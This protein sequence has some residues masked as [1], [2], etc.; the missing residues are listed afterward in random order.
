MMDSG[1]LHGFFGPDLYYREEYERKTRR[2]FAFVEHAF[3]LVNLISDCERNESLIMAAS[4][5][6]FIADD[7]GIDLENH[8]RMKMRYNAMRPRLHGKAY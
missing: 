2:G 8:I 1:Y 7:F 4:E 5:V 3:R 6:F